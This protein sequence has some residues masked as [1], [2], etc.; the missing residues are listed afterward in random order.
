MLARG[1]SIGVFQFES[2]GMRDALK[3]IKPSEFNDLVAL[4]SLYRPGAMRYIDTYARNKRNP[5]AVQYPDER[6]RP[7]TQS[8]YGV[9]LYQEQSMQIAK[10]IAGFSG[11]EADDLRKAIG[12]K[13]RERM[14]A[15]RDRFFEGARAS[16]TAESVI[17]ELWA[18]NEAASDYSFN[19]SHAA[20]Y[21]LISYRTAWLKSSYPAEYMAALI[22]SVMSTKDKVPFFVAQCEDM[23]IE[24]LPPDVNESGHDFKVVEGNIRFG[25]D[26]VKGLGH[27]AVEAI[28]RAREEGGPFSSIWDFC[29]RV[30]CQAVNRKASESL[31]KCGA[32]DSLPGTR[33]GILEVLARAQASGQQAQQDAQRGQGSFFDLD[34]GGADAGH[35][36]LPIPSLPDERAQLN[37]WE[38]ETLGLFLSS[39]PLKEVR[40]ALRARVEC[41]LADLPSRKDGDW[42]TVG[43][44]IAECKRIRTKNG[45]PMM[46][47]TLDDLEGQVELLVFNS[48]YA[49]NADKVDVDRIVIVRGRVDHKEAGETKLVAHEVEP[50]EPTRDEVLRAVEQSAAE[51]VARRLTLHV[52]PDVPD[53]F[54]EELKEVVG[55]H[56]GDHQLL[57]AVG[58]RRLLLGADY[59]VS[60]DSA[61]RTELG[62][63]Q[64]AARVVA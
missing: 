50:F 15:L 20:C 62:G 37:S 58:E 57:L 29:R 48:A 14:A 54:L 44:M 2:D 24:V 43:G 40:P 11:P 28:I 46:F 25:L 23:G 35:H 60:A 39:H 22:S 55:H 13:Q 34:E 8:S 5:D 6:L 51:P 31:V 56:R 19:R 63:L 49:A 1:D 18:V 27:Q 16:G 61:C 59:R 38:K 4:V 17:Q 32:M 30:D 53:S 9:I 47:A 64:G 36:D 33:T 26:A 10:T 7:I 3:K 41:S 45:D 21:A 12:K 52:S 42:V